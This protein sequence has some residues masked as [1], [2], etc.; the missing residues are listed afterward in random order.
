MT[1]NLLRNLCS[2]NFR[3]CGHESLANFP[4]LFVTLLLGNR[5]VGCD[6]NCVA[7]LSWNVDTF[8]TLYLD[9][10][11]HT[12]LSGD[13]L[14]DLLT[15]VIPVP[16]LQVGNPALHVLDTLT[17]LLVGRLYDSVTARRVRIIK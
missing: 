17:L 3:F 15:V 1:T 2:D 4:R 16:G 12:L 10:D 11:R 7:G 14:A 13:V 8:L 9:W 6:W 5:V